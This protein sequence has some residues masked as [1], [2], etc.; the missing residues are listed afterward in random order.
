MSS[1]LRLLLT[2]SAV[3]GTRNIRRDTI[4]LAMGDG[5][6]IQVMRVRD[7]RARRLRLSVDERG[8]RL[9]L[10]PRASAISGERFLEQHRDWLVAQLRAHAIDDLIAPL[11]RDVTAVLPL[12]GAMLPLR[13]APGHCDCISREGGRVDSQHAGRGGDA[14][15]RYDKL[16]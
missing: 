5:S 11:E 14:A 12:R 2:K 9:T 16:D 1:L 13:R 15:Q 6:S 3:P 10:P 8:A 7:P 4:T